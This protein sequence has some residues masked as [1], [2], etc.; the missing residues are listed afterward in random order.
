MPLVGWPRFTR[1]AEACGIDAGVLLKPTTIYAVHP[2]GPR[3]IEL[4]EEALELNP[5]QVGHAKAILR[6]RGNMSSA[7][8]PHIW[9][10]LLVDAAVPADTPIVSLAFGPGLTVYGTILRKL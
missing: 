3:I 9:Q 4:V 7:T 6:D 10:N 2:G 5:H 1:L 8:L